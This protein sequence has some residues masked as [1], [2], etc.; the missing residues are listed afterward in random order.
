M[1]PVEILKGGLNADGEIAGVGVSG[2]VAGIQL[3]IP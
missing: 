2:A 1:F 3:G